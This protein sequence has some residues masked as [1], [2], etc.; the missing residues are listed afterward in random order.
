MSVMPKTMLI[1]GASRGIGAQIARQAG[2]S[3]YSVAVN[4]HRNRAAAEAVAQDIERAGARA[5]IVQ[6]DVGDDAQVRAMFE[7]IDSAFGRKLDVLVNNAGVLTSN[8]IE[9]TQDA[10]LSA[11]FR[12]NVFSMFFC[13]RE[14]VQRMS[15]KHGGRGG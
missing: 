5:L 11:M 7:Q 4:Y 10:A 1:T 6:G 14:A 15:T 8:P 3:G 9:A 2:L 12:A 13:A